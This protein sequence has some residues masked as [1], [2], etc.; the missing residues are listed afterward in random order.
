MKAL[1]Y[2]LVVP[3]DPLCETI[4]S[5]YFADI[6]Y[7]SFE[8]GSSATVTCLDGYAFPDRTYITQVSCVATGQ[9]TVAWDLSS[10]EPCQSE[11]V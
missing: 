8:E 5:L 4:Q 11:H 7:T 1:Q 3:T 10:Y 6:N 2:Q 9:D